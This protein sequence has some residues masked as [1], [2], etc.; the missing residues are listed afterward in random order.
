MQ[1]EKEEAEKRRLEQEL[2]ILRGSV[3]TLKVLLL[4]LALCFFYF[5]VTFQKQYSEI[6]DFYMQSYEM[7]K[8]IIYHIDDLLEKYE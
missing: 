1:M 4:G 8:E 6:H 2:E 3:G 7:N 5:V